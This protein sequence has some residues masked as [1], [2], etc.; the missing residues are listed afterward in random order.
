MKTIN[1]V[2]YEVAPGEVITIMVT[3][4]GVGVFVAA[5]LD[6][7]TLAPLPGTAATTPTYTFTANRP[8][9]RT[10]FVMMEFSFP[11]APNTAKYDVV[12]TGSEGGSGTFTIKKTT[13]IKDPIIRFKL[14]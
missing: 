8:I 6:G 13:A 1:S 12:I 10:H 9:G 14:V 4:T 5:S 3:P 11:G 7:H 2:Q